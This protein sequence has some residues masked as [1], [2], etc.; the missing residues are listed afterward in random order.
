MKPTVERVDTVTAE[1]LAEEIAVALGHTRGGPD[2]EGVLDVLRQH[3][4]ERIEGVEQL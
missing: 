2:F 1:A 4:G 3:I